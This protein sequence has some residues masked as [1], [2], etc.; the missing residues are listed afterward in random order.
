MVYKKYNIPSEKISKASVLSALFVKNAFDSRVEDNLRFLKDNISPASFSAFQSAFISALDPENEE[1][2]EG[3]VDILDR[4]SDDILEEYRDS[5]IQHDLYKSIDYLF[6][7]LD[8]HSEDSISNYFTQTVD[9]ISSDFD[10]PEAKEFLGSGVSVTEDIYKRRE[11]Q[12]LYK[13]QKRE[14]EQYRREEAE[15]QKVWSKNYRDKNEESVK[16]SKLIYYYKSQIKKILLE[17]E[18]LEES[19]V[20]D[21]IEKS[22]E[23]SFPLAVSNL[24]YNKDQAIQNIDLVK[25]ETYKIILSTLKSEVLGIEESVKRDRTDDELRA[26]NIYK[27]TRYDLS[28]KMSEDGSIS[29]EEARDYISETVDKKIEDDISGG[30]I[31]D[32]EFKKYPYKY[33]LSY[34]REIA[35]E[36]RNRL[37]EDSP[38]KLEKG[39]VI[40]DEEKRLRNLF[41]TSRRN[42]AKFLVERGKS[43][44]IDSALEIINSEISKN[45]SE[46]GVLGEP[47]YSDLVN[48]LKNVSALFRNRG[49]GESKLSKHML[50]KIRAKNRREIRTRYAEEL[51]RD[52]PQMSAEEISDLVKL[53]KPR[54]VDKIGERFGIETV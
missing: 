24:G 9:G 39:S 49:R 3:A 28:K 43:E 45:I 1:E 25:I 31:S 13:R 52:N 41:T 33:R 54:E 15:K 37:S 14:S 32:H 6:N 2:R 12:R 42:L 16:A 20:D 26:E 38:S 27:S 51:A 47:S 4:I 29:R 40:T 44:D 30:K 46:S 53:L 18:G 7:S 35:R 48:A 11:R 21:I 8:E 10:S 17:V 50:E 34:L 22:Y 23:K 19:E 36:I 5:S